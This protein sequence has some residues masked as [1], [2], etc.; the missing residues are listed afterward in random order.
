LKRAIEEDFPIV[1]INRLVVPERNGFKPVYQMHKSFAPRASCVFRAILLAALKPAGTN[2]ISEFYKDHT[3]DPDTNGKIIIDP[4]MGG[5][6]TVVEATRL[7]IAPIGVELN[8]VPWFVVRMALAPASLK[9]LDDAF[10]RLERRMVTWSAKSV[11]ET[12]SKLYQTQP[13]FLSETGDEAPVISPS[14]IVHTYWVKSAVCTSPTCKKLVPLFTDYVVARREPSIR[15]HADCTCPNCRRKFDWETEP[16][17]LISDPRLMFHAS[18]YSAGSGRTTTRWTYAHPDG[19]LFV[20]QGESAGGQGQCRWGTVG[21]GQVCCPHCFGTITPRLAQPKAKRK[22]VSFAVLHCPKT[23]EVFQWRGGLEAETEVTSPSGH[24][25]KPLKG[26]VPDDGGFVCPHCGNP[27]SVINSIRMLPKDQR[28]PMHVYAI[29]AYCPDTD[30]RDEDDNPVETELFAEN[31]D[32]RTTTTLPPSSNLIWKNKGKFFSC[33]TT[34]DLAAY[35]A[36]SRLWD[37]HRTSKFWPK[38]EIP[39]GFNTN[40]M[41][42]HNYRF[43]HE[44]FNERQLLALS[45]LL[46]AIAQEEDQECKDLFLLAFS[47]TLERNNLFCRYFNDRNTIQGNFDQ[48]H[49]APK[50]DP[51]ENCVWGPKEIRG[52]FQNMLGRVREGVAFR[53]AVYDRDLDRLGEPDSLIFSKETIALGGAQILNGDSREIVPTISQQADA[54]ITDPPYAGN[55]NYSE[56]YDFFYVWLRLILKDR[57]DTF[58]PEYTPKL[59]EIVENETR[60]L[61]NDDFREGLRFVFERS[62]E[63]L[64]DDGLLAFTYHH[65]GN[66]QWVDLCDAVCLSGFVIEAVYPVHAEKESS[67]NLQNNEAIS[68]DLIHVCRKRNAAKEQTPRSWAGL[69]Q[70]IRQRAR[71]EIARIEGGRYGSR[72]L[73]P[74]DVR[75]VLIGK[76]LEI[77]SRHYGVVLD[78]AG[79]PMPMRDALIDIGEMV[80]QMISKESPLPA[81]L[82]GIDV[83]TRIWFRALCDV[84]EVTVDTIRKSTQGILE[85]GDLTSYKPPLVRKGRMK[86]GR[87]YEVLTPLERLD[88]LQQILDVPQPGVTMDLG[89][90]L[91]HDQVPVGA[92]LV[93]VLHLLLANAERGERLD[94]LVENYRGQREP[95]RAGLEYLKQKD[96]NRWS[97]ACD[98]LLPFY[99]DLFAQAAMTKGDD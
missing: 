84:R 89:L 16:A 17:A 91:P 93:D 19:G 21:K 86:G 9:D 88:T 81:E 71:D 51:E 23:E 97:K 52:T 49:Y 76:C 74:A 87:T 64:K 43:W 56:L 77:Y 69:R 80:E 40:Q 10:A 39:A 22:R 30:L 61:S 25:F 4:F 92:N 98:K 53:T 8:P 65:S 3:N 24:T 85:M 47:G 28:L 48:H 59:Q 57:F 29:Q 35:Q 2:I 7:G 82:D 12:L 20:C 45:T 99:S 79:K 46:E 66:Q 63:K 37:Q 36:T 94:H 41:I 90:D 78:W 27:D 1:E 18:T 42:K 72:P 5:G 11:A 44:M 50:I 83:L 58:K 32:K 15:Y 62:R 38:S 55:V 60:G 33:F 96:P 31:S 68:Y 14:N 6:T 13:P 26:P 54:I 67:L 75:I 73:S 95:I 34:K 70:L